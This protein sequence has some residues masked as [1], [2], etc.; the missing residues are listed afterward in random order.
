MDPA[1]NVNLENDKQSPMSSKPINS[2][3][4]QAPVDFA[5]NK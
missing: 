5:I 4:V 2:E 3:K 1:I